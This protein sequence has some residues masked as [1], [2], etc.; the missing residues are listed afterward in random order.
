LI[1]DN[2]KGVPQDYSEAAK[3]YRKA[4]E[5]GHAEAQ[6]NLGVSC[7]KGEGVKQDYSLAYIWLSLSAS[8]RGEDY[9]EASKARD[10]VATMLPPEQLMKAQQMTREWE[11]MHQGK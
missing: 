1:Y 2:G 8:R 7:A 5:Q 3:W 9:N 10:K 4:A 6:Y 11:G